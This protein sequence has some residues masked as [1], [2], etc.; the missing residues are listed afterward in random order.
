MKR[1][2]VIHTTVAIFLAAYESTV[3]LKQCCK[4]AGYYGQNKCVWNLPGCLT[5]CHVASLSRRFCLSAP[6]GLLGRSMSTDTE[7]ATAL[8]VDH[9]AAFR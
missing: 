8:I 9:R 3:H 4:A 2:L 6:S 1:G 7:A 5:V